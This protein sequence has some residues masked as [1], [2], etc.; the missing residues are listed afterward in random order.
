MEMA[1]KE[2]RNRMWAFIILGFFALVSVTT[3][4]YNEYYLYLSIYLWFGL[5]YGLALQYGRFCFSSAF[6]DLF[7]VG[8]ARMAVGITIAIVLFALVASLVTAQ[9]LSTF[10]P[11]P[12]G[13]HAVIAGFIFGM[14]MV[15]AGGCAWFFV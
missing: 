3:F 11:A 14:G 6:R 8:V 9:G 4:V 1:Y 2:R 7:A 12:S 15:F 5:V 10:H 13:I